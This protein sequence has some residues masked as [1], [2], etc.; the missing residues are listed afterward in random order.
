MYGGT[1]T[2]MERLLADAQKLTGVK[3]DISNLSDV[4]EAIHAI[5]KNLGVTGTTA[6]E[7]TATISGS[8]N[9]AKKAFENFL[10][11]TASGKDVAK[12]VTIAAQNISKELIKILP[13]LASGLAELI[14]G[15]IPLIP[16]LVSKLAPVLSRAVVSLVKSLIGII[17]SSIRPLVIAIGG[18]VAA[19][20]TIST[21]ITIIKTVKTVL[22]SLKAVMMV[23]NAVML[24][25]PIGIIVAAVAGLVAI[26]VVLWKK[27]EKFRNFWINLWEGIKKVFSSVINWIKTNWKS[28][29]LFLINPFWGAFKYLYDHCEK[30]R[31]FV[32]NF[33]TNIVNFV[34]KIP[35]F[36]A[37]IP[38]QIIA[39]IQKIPYYIGYA[40]GWIVGQIINFFARVWEFITVDIPGMVTF[41]VTW[42]S[43]LPG[44]IWNFL[45][46]TITKVK[47]WAVNFVAKAKEAAKN[48][49][50]NVINWIKQ[51]PSRVWTWLQNMI[52]RLSTWASEMWK[53]SKEGAKK[54]AEAL[55]NGI[56]NLPERVGNIGRNIVRGLWNGIKSA[57]DWMIDKVK[58]FAKGI[59]DGMKSAL[60]IH[61]PSKEF[62]LIGKFSVLGYTE[63]LENMKQDVEKAIDGTFSLSPNVTN[64]ASTNFS[65]SVNVINNI[66]MK[67]DPLGQMVNQIKTFSGGAKNDYNYGKA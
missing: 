9:M 49:V 21:V 42:I 30:F 13:Y 57:K 19:F 38:E 34:K 46:N 45:V 24:A 39:F 56:K 28:I 6:K 64:S 53:K 48:F 44:R 58:S 33:V 54:F 23:I 65:P 62:A 55:I 29:L 35:S 63:A 18:I 51:L 61:S 1:K 22:M 59:L 15:L 10:S 32:N 17:P 26:F 50:N 41:V 60:G 14:N 40:L 8:M 25:N 20:K 4:Y 37:S 3:Y 7:A 47:V 31:T 67:Q 5:Q 52:N 11:G 36:I 12:A 2:E 43:Q 66:E 16:D 27:C